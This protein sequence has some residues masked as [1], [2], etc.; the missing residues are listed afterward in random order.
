MKL[1]RYV[2]CVK[3]GS[4]GCV[5]DDDAVSADAGWVHWCPGCNRIHAIAVERALENGAKWTFNGDHTAPT[6]TPSVKVT[7]G[8]RPTVPVGRPDAGRINVCHYFIRSGQIE[9]CADST[10]DLAGQIVPL[11]DIPASEL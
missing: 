6:F 9:Y 2:Y 5:N 7:V 11:P 4:N 10:H 1:Q 3:P 8:P